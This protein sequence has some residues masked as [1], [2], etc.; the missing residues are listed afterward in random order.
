MGWE[1]RGNYALENNTFWSCFI[2]KQTE[3]LVVVD[4]ISCTIAEVLTMNLCY[5]A[6]I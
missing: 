3:V 4:S 5:V 6:A 2:I 1:S